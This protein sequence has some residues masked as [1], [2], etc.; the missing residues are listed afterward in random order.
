MN[1]R[2]GNLTE[3]ILAMDHEQRFIA[4]LVLATAPENVREHVHRAL[5]AA[6]ESPQP[7]GQPDLPAA[8]VSCA[9][10]KL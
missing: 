8:D 6:E 10:A 7:P 3:R 9:K 1:T 4:L 5:D 2:A